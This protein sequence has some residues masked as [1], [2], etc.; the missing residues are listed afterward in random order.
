MKREKLELPIEAHLNRGP[1]VVNLK[2][3]PAL[4]VLHLVIEQ[5]LELGFER[6]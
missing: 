5:I 1:T 6:Q 3:L 2:H 4:G